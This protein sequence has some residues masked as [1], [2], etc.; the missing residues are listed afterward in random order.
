MFHRCSMG[1]FD[2][3]TF[4]ELAKVAGQAFSSTERGVSLARSVKSLF[5]KSEAATDSDLNAAVAELTSQ[6]GDAALANAKLKVQLSELLLEINQQKARDDKLARYALQE[7]DVGSFVYSLREEYCGDEPAHNICPNCA[8]RGKHII[9]QP[10]YEGVGS[11]H[12]ACPECE[13]DFGFLRSE[14]I[15]GL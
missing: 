9:L 11:Y 3:Q 8:D 13:A 14:P 4:S 12:L 5:E 7:R 2:L 15:N 1:D 6:I 10:K